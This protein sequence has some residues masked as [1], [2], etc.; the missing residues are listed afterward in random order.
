MNRAI[1]C[2]IAKEYLEDSDVQP[3]SECSPP[4]SASFY[5]PAR[6]IRA[7]F[8]DNHHGLTA[9]IIFLCP[10]ARCISDGGSVEY[11]S[12]CFN[13]FNK[14][15]G[16]ELKGEYAFIYAL[17]VYV[18]RPGLI[19]K[20]Q[21]YELK[22]EGTKY[23]CDTDFDKLRHEGILDLELA[24]R[25]ILQHQ[26]SFLVRTLRPASDIISIPAK[27][28]LPI[29]ED[30]ELKGEGTF[31]EVRCFEFQ[32]DEYRSRDF[33]EH[34][35][36]FARKIFKHGMQK[37]AAKEWYNLQRL[38]EDHPHLM[39]ALGAY[40]HGSYF[41]ILQEEA[42]QSLHD[43]LKEPGDRFES[44]ELWTQMQGI[45]EGLN[46]LHKLYEG[47]KIAY[48]QDLK[49]ANILIVKRKLKIADF[50]LLELKPVTLPGDTD[51]TGIPNNHVTGFYAAPR[52]AK[53]TRECDIWSLGCIMSEVATFD[54][55]GPEGVSHYKHAR[56]ADGASGH[57]PPRFYRGKDVKE[58]VL[59]MHTQLY[60]RVQSAASDNGNA[61]DQFQRAFY[62]K[63]FFGL[64]DKMFKRDR[65]SAGL[66]D[67][68]DDGISLDAAHIVETL[69][70]LR[71]EALPTTVLDDEVEQLS[72]EQ[73]LQDAESLKSS[74]E[75]HFIGFGEILTPRNRARFSATTLT[76]L[77]QYIVNLQH[78]Q[79]AERRQQG[80]TRLA[81]FLERLGEFG[82]LVATLSRTED[83]MGFVWGPVK[84]LLETTNSCTD[85]F[86]DIL[87]IY[88]QIGRVQ[89]SLSMYKELFRTEPSLT[90]ILIATYSEIIEVNR[91]L[92]IYFQQRLWAELFA[93]TWKRHKSRLSN[94]I[95]C[96]MSRFKLVSS[97][98]TLEQLDTLVTTSSREEATLNVE[99]DSEDL[100]RRHA[101]YTWIKPT[102]MENDQEYLRRIRHA[103]PGTCSWLL[104]DETF[105]EWFE[106]QES[107]MTGSNLLWLNGKP[108]SGKTVLASFV[109]EEARKLESN[110]TVLF[111]YF[112]REDSD[113]NSFLSMARTLLSQILEQNHYTLDYFY[114]KCCS[115]GSAVLSSRLLVEELLSFALRNCQS[116]YIVLDGLDECCTRKE[117]GEIASWFRDLIENGPPEIRNGLHCMFI[118]QHDSARKDYRDLPSITADDDNNEEDIEAFCK[119]QAEK[120]VTNLQIAEHKALEIAE[121]VSAAAEGVFLFAHLVWINLCG[122]S[123]IYSLEREME[124]FATD[125]DTL[126]KAYSRIMQTIIEK[127]V[128]AQRGEALELLGWLV[129]A[130][131]S[132]KMHEVQ[133]LRSVDFERRAVEFERRR[134]RV[135]VKDLCESL[136]DVR[137]DGSIEL[138]HTTAKTYLANSGLLN[139]ITGELPIATLCI[140]YLNLPSFQR[141]SEE[142]M[143]AGEYGFMEYSML[144]WLRHLEAGMSSTHPDQDNI[145]MSLTESL[146]VLV[147]QYWNE[148]SASVASISRSASKRTRDVLQQFSHRESFPKLQLALVLTDK[149]LKHFG[150]VRPEE[151]AL[152]ILG[153][154]KAVRRCIETYIV[155]SSNLDVA[156]ALKDMYGSNLF[157][158]PRFS[159]RYFTDGF[160]TLE[161]RERHFQRHVLP[162]RCTDEH[163]R[164]SQIGFATQAQLE[165]HLREN[166]PNMTEPHHNFPTDEEIV[167][168]MREV[169]PEPEVVIEDEPQLVPEVQQPV[170]VP[171]IPVTPT[172]EQAESQPT[173][174]RE[175]AKR[176][177]TKREY[178][179][180]H[181]DKTFTKKWNWE[182]HLRTHGDNQR[183]QC[184][185]CDQTCARQ[186]D[187]A[188]H[189]RLHDPNSAVKC[190]GVL[191]NGR[192][193]GCGTNF[194]RL[195]VLRT[196]HKSK[197]GRRCV[198]ERDREAQSTAS[199]A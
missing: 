165:R 3:I 62:N 93:T 72:L 70:K 40:W 173:Q 30:K 196:H 58:S 90:E 155:H 134:L 1:P 128:A 143:L 21:K 94:I 153:V 127:P 120:L 102:D 179:C 13:C 14:L 101:V 25:K 32:D 154:V 157:K 68:P 175:V 52:Q 110:P 91:L 78:T 64:L 146:E 41:F 140:D 66:L 123:S 79:H 85:A 6:K 193:W 87:D 82:E 65:V 114:S 125:L 18:R 159:C 76:A 39:V 74:M 23:L 164:G 119:V 133:T 56:M 105:Q 12:E 46:T 89:P 166:H 24:Q 95:S 77:K 29:K 112:K 71:T 145:Y 151:S 163:C 152:R 118:S 60:D 75:A 28:L 73:Y 135:H 8:E 88:G 182:S 106:H 174:Q 44:Q 20:F 156:G 124:T 2:Q 138:V 169:S 80:L 187:L 36:R 178:Q 117:R 126:D 61:T 37:S 115:S 121:R 129:Y 69:E 31:A 141:P 35:T 59:L 63:E 188:R 131:R 48:H 45:A 100:G 147:E 98:A 183:L 180:A 144:Y 171:D 136:V 97:Q 162:A 57:D 17:L 103:Y 177:K 53:Y 26:Y 172:P 139:D 150:D 22:L 191:P 198:A 81:P 54:I 42:E 149:E 167:E 184:P 181:C 116:A 185:N 132:L 108:G 15:K 4:S 109:V 170:E 186:G 160:T 130:K 5:I 197:K 113:R 96:M 190:G 111:F 27:E 107:I 168:S 104:S 51:M 158:C 176:V 83:I 49:P 38:S 99:R 194:A 161:E 7:L 43:Y 192:R 11:R 34:V 55:H 10:C 84:F 47:T 67:V 189:M 142:Q 16:R 50:G 122:Q 92:V 9:E 19:Q 195:D 148:P 137:E 86:N 199:T 33:G